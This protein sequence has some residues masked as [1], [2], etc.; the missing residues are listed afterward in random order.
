LEIYSILLLA[1][2]LAMDAFSVATITGFSLE[3]MDLRQA[4][5]VSLNFG[6]FHVFMPI[7]GWLVG[8]S[9]VWLISAYD[10]WVA[11]LLLAYVGGK[12]FYDAFRGDERIEPSRVL[13]NL[14]LLLFS[15]A[16][17]IDA[18]AV[19]LSFYL[20]NIPILMPAII[21]GAVTFVFTFLGI[22]LGNRVGRFIGR[23]TQIFGGVVLIAIGLRI[24]I[25]HTI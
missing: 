7:T 19:G 18:I 16:V 2:G 4:S 1:V 17:S 25:T 5:K 21:I 14:N 12:M 13:N 11:F 23:W 15:V 6:A 20:E 9:I 22:F 3:H 10:H 8:S 24:V